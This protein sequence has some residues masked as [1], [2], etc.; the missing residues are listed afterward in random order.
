MKDIQDLALADGDC[1]LTKNFELFGSLGRTLC[2]QIITTIKLFAKLENEFLKIYD[3]KN[4]P[5]ILYTKNQNVYIPACII[6]KEI[7][8]LSNTRNCYADIPIQLKFKNETKNAFLRYDNI[9][10]KTSK[11]FDFELINSLVNIENS[12]YSI[13]RSKITNNIIQQNDQF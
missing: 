5:F 10:S 7:T 3:R 9:I 11:Q 6:I 4:N 13:K 8:N 12:N 2:H 1:V